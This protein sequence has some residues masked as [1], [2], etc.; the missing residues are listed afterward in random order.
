MKKVWEFLKQNK[1]F[2]SGLGAAIAVALQQ[3]VGA[4]TIEWSVIGFAVLMAILSYIANKWRGAGL[5]ITGII[6]TLCATFIQVWD[7]GKID[8]VQ[9]VILTVIAVLSA[10]AP[11]PK[12]DTYEKPVK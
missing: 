1:V 4:E 10:V 3:F 8:W 11:P 12:P 7:G 2:L 6:G 5:T 9:L